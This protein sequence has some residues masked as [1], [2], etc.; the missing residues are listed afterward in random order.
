M[1]R[2]SLPSLVLALALVGCDS[3]IAMTGAPANA[4]IA[5]EAAVPAIL[6]A[7][8]AGQQ[9][10]IDNPE[11][12]PEAVRSASNLQV[13]VAGAKM[14]VTRAPGGF[15]T[16]V[17]PANVQPQIDQAGNLKALFIMDD[18]TSQIVTLATG[19]PVAFAQPPVVTGPSPAYLTRGLAVTLRANTE[20]SPEAY[21]FTW[22]YGLSPQGPWQSIPGQGKEVEW[23][24]GAAGNYYIKVDSVDRATQKSYATIT[25]QAVV[26]VTEADNLVTTAPASGSIER[27]SQVQ[28]TFNRP[29]GVEGTNLSYAWS[30]AVSPQGPWSPLS[31]DAPSVSFLPTNTGSYYVRV[32]VTNRDTGKVSTFT[33]SKAVVTVTEG[34]SIV[35]ASASSVERGDKVQLSL[36][37]ANPGEGPFT[38]Y[39]ALAG[40][41]SAWTQISGTGSTVD[42]VVNQAGSYNFRVD[43]PQA[44]GVKSFT[45]NE[46]VLSVVERQPLIQSDPPNATIRPGSSVTVKL[47]ARGIEEG[48]YR[49]V[50]Y[51][52]TN[53]MGGWQTLP[54]ESQAEQ[55]RKTYSWKTVRPNSNFIPPTQPGSYYV[56]VD[57]FELTGTA[58]YSFTSS[59]PVVFVEN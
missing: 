31:G 5:L 18:R 40:G 36:N 56:R 43:I 2:L 4:P 55:T 57:A 10:V 1:S 41:A 28:L 54:F 23:T 45:T 33:T 9:V 13:A 16:F 3:Q 53:P 50:W 17:I 49:F 32:D 58:R 51:A 35:K 12:L 8:A 37:I 14:T 19:S 27:G 30:T 52:S 38:W 21:Q 7:S 59:E 15:Y 47:N 46:P 42:L 20:A 11:R 44:S 39:Y 29:A 48:K 26:F 34:A 24:P 22:A 6:N 25:P